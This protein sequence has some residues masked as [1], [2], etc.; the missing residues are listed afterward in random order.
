MQSHRH[1][2]SLSHAVAVLVRRSFFKSFLFILCV[3]PR[4]ASDT[5]RAEC[6]NRMQGVASF[7]FWW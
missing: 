1:L 4:R 7:F 5:E 3:R 6:T 2:S